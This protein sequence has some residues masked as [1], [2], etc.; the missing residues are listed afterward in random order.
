MLRRQQ[1]PQP[2]RRPDHPQ[3]RVERVAHVELRSERGVGV[4]VVH[5]ERDAA[6]EVVRPG[7]TALP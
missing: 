4:G 1:A 6:C 2:D 5:L 3:R 7:P